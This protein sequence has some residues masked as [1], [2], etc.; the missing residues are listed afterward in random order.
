MSELRWSHPLGKGKTVQKIGCAEYGTK[1]SDVEAIVLV[2]RSAC[3]LFIANNTS[4]FWPEY[5]LGPHLGIS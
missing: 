4:P 1:L 5:L 3:N 2:F